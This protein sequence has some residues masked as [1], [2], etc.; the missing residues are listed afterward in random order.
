VYISVEAVR[1]R[2]VF[3]GFADAQAVAALD[4]ECHLSGGA[5]IMLFSFFAVIV[6]NRGILDID[7][8]SSPYWSLARVEWGVSGDRSHGSCEL[9]STW[10][11]G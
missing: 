3:E 4:S 10:A 11:G 7:T 9:R 8:G 1:R 2:V 5:T 6:S